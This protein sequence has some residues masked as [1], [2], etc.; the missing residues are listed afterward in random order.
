MNLLLASLTGLAC[1]T[2]LQGNLFLFVSLNAGAL[3]K[4]FGLNLFHTITKFQVLT[5]VYQILLKTVQR[6]TGFLVTRPR[7]FQC[8]FLLRA[9]YMQNN[10]L[11]LKMRNRVL[12]DTTENILRR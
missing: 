5:Q 1:A 8:V 2:F 6:K 3:W 11:T 10:S 12:I 9:I 4:L 7:I